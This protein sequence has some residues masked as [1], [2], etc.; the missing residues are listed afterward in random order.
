LLTGRT[1]AGELFTAFAIGGILPTVYNGSIG[2][3][4]VLK[5]HQMGIK[6]GIGKKFFSLSLIFFLAGAFLVI[7]MLAYPGFSILSKKSNFWTAV[8]LSLSA[9]SIML[10]AMHNR[11]LMLQDEKNVEVFGIDV[12]S[13]IIIV[14][15]VP[16]FYYLLGTRS[17]E[18]L[19]LFSA[20]LT[21]CLYWRSK[22]LKDYYSIMAQNAVAPP[23]YIFFV[24]AGLI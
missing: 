11:L 24:I 1:L 19:Y 14:T 8:G 17:L 23:R 12:I 7:L 6:T 15:A 5:K 2:P 3:S 22:S 20:V 9:G 21:F 13:N 4:L 16:Y 10:N 18:T